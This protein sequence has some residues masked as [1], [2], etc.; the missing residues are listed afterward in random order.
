IWARVDPRSDSLGR[1]LSRCQASSI[2]EK[3]LM[4]VILR[5]ELVNSIPSDAE[6]NIVILLRRS[7]KTIKNVAAQCRGDVRLPES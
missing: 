3:E 4:Y 2:E 1:Y 6:F 5:V 7:Q